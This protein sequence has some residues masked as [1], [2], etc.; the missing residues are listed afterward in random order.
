MTH[1]LNL[2]GILVS[3][4]IGKAILAM[5]ILLAVRPLLSRAAFQRL[6]WNAPLAEF[7][8]GVCILGLLVLL[9]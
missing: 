1:V 9:T 5:L 2:D 7:A 3:A 6:V 8:L 4:F